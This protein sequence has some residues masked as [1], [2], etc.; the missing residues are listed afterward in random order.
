MGLVNYGIEIA[1]GIVTLIILL[2]AARAMARHNQRTALVEFVLAAAI[3]ILI[4]KFPDQFAQGVQ[5][6]WNIMISKLS[7]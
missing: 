6:V 4:A 3:V 5:T 2:N 7:Q 1:G